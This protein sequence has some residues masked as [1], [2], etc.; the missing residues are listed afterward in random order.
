MHAERPAAFAASSIVSAAATTSFAALPGCAMHEAS[1]W[2][3]PC[4]RLPT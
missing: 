1:P 2:G 3:A 4:R